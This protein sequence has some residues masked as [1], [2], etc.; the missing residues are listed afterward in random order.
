MS[1]ELRL[2]P[3]AELD[4][5]DAAFWYEDQS[6]G[7]GRQFLDGVSASFSSISKTPK[8][9]PLVYRN[10]RRALISRFPFGVYFVMEKGCVV[11]LAIIHG[12]RDPR[13][14]KGRAGK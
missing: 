12:S 1:F 11:V 9:Y 4:L 10:V 14:W 13:L 6:S 8:R 3:E 2:R 5:T 7:L